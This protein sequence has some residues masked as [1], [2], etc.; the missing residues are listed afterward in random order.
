MKGG[1]WVNSDRNFDSIWQAIP[2]LCE[3]ITTEGWLEMM[4]KAIDG[5]EVD[6]APVRNN[7]P[8]MTIFFISFIIL[9]NVFVLNLFVGIVIDKFN[10]L[11]EK[12]LGFHLMT[13]D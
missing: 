4:Y 9:G 2:V 6:K 1:D 3:M 8:L 12:I 13:K 11:K 7:N 10:R 5:T